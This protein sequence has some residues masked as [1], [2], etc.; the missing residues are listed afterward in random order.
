MI[1]LKR[2]RLR[3][4]CNSNKIAPHLCC[5]VFGHS[6]TMSRKVILPCAKANVLK[7]H[8][9]LRTR[10]CVTATF[11]TI[12]PSAMTIFR[13][14]GIS[15]GPSKQKSDCQGCSVS[16]KEIPWSD[17]IVGNQL[18]SNLCSI[19]FDSIAEPLEC[20]KQLSTLP[21]TDSNLPVLNL[22]NCL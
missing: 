13:R 21:E 9:V 20:T 1:T 8:C 5:C 6:V 15:F 10:V 4:N 12:A 11:P 22:L 16:L 3:F 18:Q 14:Q 7:S 19:E 2:V 17:L